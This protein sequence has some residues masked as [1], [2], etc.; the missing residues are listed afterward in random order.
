VVSAQELINSYQLKCENDY[1]KML[2]ETFKGKLPKK[3]T[4]SKEKY[5]L[6]ADLIDENFLFFN[7]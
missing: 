7:S 1:D 3:R 6:Q 4:F 5:E 2:Y